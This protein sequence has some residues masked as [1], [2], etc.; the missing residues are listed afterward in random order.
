MSIYRHHSHDVPE[1][2][3]SSLPDLIFSVL[4]FF[5]IVTHMRTDMVKVQY[6]VPQGKELQKLAHNPAVTHIY[7]GKCEGRSVEC[8]DGAGNASDYQIQVNDKIV[9]VGE[10]ADY[11]QA[12]SAKVDKDAAE[13]LSAVISA[14]RSAP[15][16]LIYEVKMALRKA[17]ILKVS[18]T[19]VNKKGKAN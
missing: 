7:I 2:N 16:G 15:M 14:D 11:L 13:Q 19:G 8:E 3:T 5:M 9:S 6:Q 1:L 17:N 10:L 4:F 12:T 18:Y